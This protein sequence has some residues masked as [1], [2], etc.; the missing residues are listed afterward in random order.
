[1]SSN[2]RER[3]SAVEAIRGISMMGVIGIHIGAEYL[4]NSSPNLHLVALFDI[5]T[6][7]SVPI[8]FFISAFGLLYGQNLSAP[9]PY[10]NFLVR[11][12][13]TVVIP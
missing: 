7:F 9:F 10:R 12:T 6:R 5:G 2:K 4:A 13:R 3:V 1:M 11:R 8:F